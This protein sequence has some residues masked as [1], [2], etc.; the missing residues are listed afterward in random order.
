MQGRHFLSLED[1]SAAEISALLQLARDLKAGAL[2]A[3][4]RSLPMA[5]KTLA[6][7]FQKRSTRTRVS[8]ETGMSKLGGHALFLGSEDIQVS[9]AT[10]CGMVR[11]A[12]V[13]LVDYLRVQ[14]FEACIQSSI[15]TCV[16][17]IS[18]HSG[19]VVAFGSQLG[20]NESLRD[21]S[22]VL[23]RFNDGILARVFEHSTLEELAKYSTSPI[24][25]ALSDL[26]HPLQTL[27]DI[28]TVQEAYGSEKGVTVAW[29]GDGNNVIH[30]L[31]IGGAKVSGCCASGK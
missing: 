22:K 8:T 26:H 4:A 16:S 30:S 5:G 14:R 19:D 1:F 7:I 29:I 20:T 2:D 25:N 9:R 24:I 27:A 15:G 31:L 10:D 13:L 12:G 18:T 3:G 17:W 6:M 28:M 21:T 11:F 23:C